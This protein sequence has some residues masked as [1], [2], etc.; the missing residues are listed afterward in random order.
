MDNLSN[1]SFISGETVIDW[2]TLCMINR[3]PSG[4]FEDHFEHMA[5]G[6]DWIRGLLL[7]IAPFNS[8]SNGQSP[9]H[10][11]LSAQA[12]WTTPTSRGSLTNDQMTTSWTFSR[13]IVC[14]TSTNY[15]SYHNVIIW[16]RKGAFLSSSGMRELFSCWGV[17]HSKQTPSRQDLLKQIKLL[18]KVTVLLMFGFTAHL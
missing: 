1:S 6:R 14:P 18:P 16:Y 8:R 9:R 4:Q 15:T 13:T 2:S 12:C 10:L 17:I 5:S 11:P 7:Q 3:N